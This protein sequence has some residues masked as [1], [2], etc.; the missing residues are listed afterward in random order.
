[1]ATSDW[2]STAC[3]LCGTNCGL[4]VK[5]EDDRIVKVRGDRQNPFSRGYVCRKSMAVGSYQDHNQRVLSPLRQGA[6]GSFDEIDWDTA[7]GEVGAKLKAILDEHGPRSVAFIG[8]GGQANHLDIPYAAFFLRSLGS[9]YNYTALGQEYTQKYWLNGHMF[10]RESVDF[11]SDHARCDVYLVI[12]SN[13]WMSGGSQ[14]SREVIMGIS[15][16]SDR[17]LIVVDPRRHET[18]KRADSFLQIKPGTDMYFFLALIHVVVK[19]GLCKEDYIQAHAPDW[20][21]VKWLADL[22]TPAVAARLCDLDE[23]QIVETARTFGKAKKGA[24]HVDLGIYHGIHMMESLYLE[25]VLLVLTGNIG[26]PGGMV[27]P[28][29]F[30]SLGGG[31][32]DYKSEPWKTR[33]AGISAINGQFPPNAMPEE[34]LTPGEDRLRAVIVEGSNPLRSYADSLKF[35]E[36][37]KA[38]DLLVVIEPAMTESARLAH[39]V[40]PAKCGYEKFEASFFPKGYPEIY[41]HLRHPVCNG[42]E[43]AKQ[44]CDIYRMILDKMGVDLSQLFPFALMDEAEQNGDASP[45]LP[46]VRVMANFF[47]SRHREDLIANG[48]ISGEGDDAAELFQAI[49]DHPEGVYLCDTATENR[50]ADVIKTGDGKIHLVVPE[51]LDVLRD[52][53]IPENIELGS[54]EWPLVLQTG[55]RSDYVANT[56]MRDNAWREKKMPVNSLRMSEAD[57]ERLGIADGETVRLT[58]AA[59]SATI[60]AMVTDDIYPGMVSTSHGFGLMLTNKETGALEQ[61]GVNAN[62]LATAEH[63]EPISGV[64]YHRHIPCR[65]EKL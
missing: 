23:A 41:Y 62:E 11:A 6:D 55:E 46:L 38:L 8:G 4:E 24:I 22:V 2:Q 12:G 7:A 14:R 45:V 28:E 10:G 29:T 49:L 34:I 5:V 50:L 13:P 27:F 61:I 32:R 64:P 52:L 63:R 57:A 21:E 15:K 19:E 39:Y 65:V 18:A 26:E 33:V 36:A 30:M 16:S 20:E 54:E 51:I 56:I 37:F 59:S 3:V 25:R 53:E 42:P 60:P 58:T 44:E 9:K 40:L 35:E 1:M 48:I 43:L 47:V 31:G 17:T